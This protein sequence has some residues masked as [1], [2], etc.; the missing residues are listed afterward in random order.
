MFIRVLF[1]FEQT[2]TKNERRA[3]DNIPQLSGW[4]T[5]KKE[6][7]MEDQ[8]IFMNREVELFKEEISDGVRWFVTDCEAGGYCEQYYTHKEA[9]QDYN[10]R[11]QER[12]EK[13]Y[14]KS[15]SA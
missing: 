12:I 3:V 15:H 10:K 1:G 4:R 8:K 7:K 11:V 6:L 9:L 2:F 5:Q 13:Y 14:T